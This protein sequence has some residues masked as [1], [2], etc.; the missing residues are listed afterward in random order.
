MAEK[1][2]KERQQLEEKFEEKQKPEIV[3][4]LKQM[5][6]VAR[7]EVKNNIVTLKNM[8][9]GNQLEINIDEI[10]TKPYAEIPQYV[11][12]TFKN[13]A[14]LYKL[15]GVDDS[16]DDIMKVFCYERGEDG[17]FIYEKAYTVADFL[18]DDKFIE[19]KMD[20]IIL[21]DIVGENPDSKVK[22]GEHAR[23]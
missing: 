23:N 20:S 17:K 7:E 2:D 16:S 14:K 9:D 8:V 10:K 6:E 15:L 5:A 22:Q 4:V 18:N 1:F 13:Q 11:V 19:N 3:N 21:K 12:D